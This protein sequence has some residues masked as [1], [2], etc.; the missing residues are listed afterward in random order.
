MNYFYFI[1]YFFSPSFANGGFLYSQLLA[2]DL[3]LDLEVRDRRYLLGGEGQVLV[4]GAL[5]RRLRVV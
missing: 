5:G 2:L 4:P 3:V 1:F